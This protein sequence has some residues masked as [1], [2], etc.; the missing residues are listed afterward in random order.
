[1][2]RNSGVWSTPTHF[3]AL[4]GGQGEHTG[5]DFGNGSL[6][7]TP[8]SQGRPLLPLHKPPP[9][10][11]SSHPELSRHDDSCSHSVFLVLIMCT[12]QAY[13]PPKTE[14]VRLTVEDSPRL[15]RQTQGQ[16][17]PFEL[18]A[19][20][21]HSAAPCLSPCVCKVSSSRARLTGR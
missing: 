18:C 4:L 21:K 10:S 14:G 5:E 12:Q 8:P 16:L 20:A 13:E 15:W 3:R 6:T 1:M 19:S 2:V 9:A 11:L 17:R 7:A